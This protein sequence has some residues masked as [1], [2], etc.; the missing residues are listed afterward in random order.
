MPCDFQ[1]RCDSTK[2]R[3]GTTVKLTSRRR[4][5]LFSNMIALIIALIVVAA[6]EGSDLT[7][8]KFV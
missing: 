6:S 1:S 8:Y 4:Q 2:K 7:Q 5:R 3:Y